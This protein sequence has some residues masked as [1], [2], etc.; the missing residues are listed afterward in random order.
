MKQF[1]PGNLLKFNFQQVF[2]RHNQPGQDRVPFGLRA[3]MKRL[4]PFQVYF[5]AGATFGGWKLSNPNDPTGSTF[6]GMTTGDLE[7]ENSVDG[8]T[9]ITWYGN[10]D[11]TTPATCGFWEVWLN[12]NGVFYYSEVLQVYDEELVPAPTWRIRFTNG[13]DKD[14]VLYQNVY[15]QILSP[16]KCA[17]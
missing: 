4:M 7:V 8:G 6:I 11:L 14:F 2:Q 9:W 17:W 3:P 15:Q 16:K 13:M 10:V 1:N 5:P 12:I